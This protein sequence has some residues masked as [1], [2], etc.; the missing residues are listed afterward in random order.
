MFIP[1]SKE[2]VNINILSS[3]LFKD[4]FAENS[5]LI[6]HSTGFTCFDIP[7][8]YFDTNNLTGDYVANGGLFPRIYTIYGESETGKTSL[9]VQVTGQAV[10]RNYGSNS[11][12][13]DA[14]GNCG[15][16]RIKDLNNWSDVEYASKC[17]YIPP[18]PPITINRV[19]DI[20]RR[21]AYSK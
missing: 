15:P 21:I 16:E 19:Y 6:G 1:K 11:V 8:S 17:L 4:I 5:K 14:E 12:I 18:S 7:T 13:I 3:D 20:I 9:L 10:D 2:K